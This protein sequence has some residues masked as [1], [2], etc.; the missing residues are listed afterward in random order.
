M[1]LNPRFQVNSDNGLEYIQ[2]ERGYIKNNEDFLFEN[3]NINTS[4]SYVSSGKAEI[5]ED[6]NILN[7]EENPKVIIYLNDIEEK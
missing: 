6:K 7:L 4:F 3:V 2:S 1:I 5:I